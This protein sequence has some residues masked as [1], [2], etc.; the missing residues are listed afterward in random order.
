MVMNRKNLV[1]R[2]GV[3]AGMVMFTGLGSSMVIFYP[4]RKY[5]R[6]IDYYINTV[7]VGF[8]QVIGNEEIIRRALEKDPDMSIELTDEFKHLSGYNPKKS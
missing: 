2:I 6:A 7:K 8:G 5:R 3:C 1:D 4:F